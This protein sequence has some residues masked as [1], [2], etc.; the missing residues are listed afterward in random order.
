MSVARATTPPVSH[1][2]RFFIDG[3]W[4]QPSS[5]AT[6]DVIDSGTEELYYTIASAAGSD[7][8]HAVTAARRAF[9]D[10]DWPR[11]THA[12]RAAVI[13]ELAA[14]RSEERRVGK[15]CVR[16]CRSRWSPYH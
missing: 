13:R 3:A 5:D 7:I 1:A 15:E 16:L 12:E 8:D 9:D 10:G 11:L 2:D 6:I 4:V 14:G